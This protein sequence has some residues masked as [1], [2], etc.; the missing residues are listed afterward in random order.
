MRRRQDE[1]ATGRDSDRTRVREW[2]NDVQRQTYLRSVDVDR[3]ED[4][5]CEGAHSKREDSQPSPRRAHL[6]EKKEDAG[7]YEVD[8]QRPLTT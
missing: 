5:G 8:G 6:Y 2:Q 7:T 4:G 3:I 1:T